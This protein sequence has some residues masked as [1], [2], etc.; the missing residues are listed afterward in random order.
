MNVFSEFKAEVFHEDGQY[1]DLIDNMATDTWQV[2]TPF[3]T[4]N[5]IIISISGNSGSSGLHGI[6]VLP[7]PQQSIHSRNRLSISII[8]L[9]W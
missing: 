1:L 9:L 8:D 6:G 3:S 5:I 4:E 7:L 2:R